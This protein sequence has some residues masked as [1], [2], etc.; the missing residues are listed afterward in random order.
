MR[1]L[2]PGARPLRRTFGR[3]PAWA[4][5]LS[6]LLHG[7]ALAALLGLLAPEAVHEPVRMTGIPLV[8]VG[9]G[10]G[11]TARRLAELPPP[12]SP[13]P[14]EAPETPPVP[15]IPEAAPV[16]PLARPGPAHA[17]PDTPP[18]SEAGS[19]PLPPPDLPSPVAAPAPGQ[20]ASPLALDELPLPP[21]PPSPPQRRPA[22][23]PPAQAAPQP[24]PGRAKLA[25]DASVGGLRL[26]AG[27][28]GLPGESRGPA[29]PAAG[30]AEAI[31]LP[32]AGIGHRN[33][34]FVG[35]RLRLSDNG[36]VVEAKVAV[37]SGFPALDDWARTRIKRCRFTPALRDGRPVWSSYNTSVYF[38]EAH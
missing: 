10:E 29:M 36:R 27:S 35:L 20:G 38:D 14:P 12:A 32:P 17:A 3:A 5:P 22:P 30:C 37:S 23:P 6:L 1:P 7:A 28:G 13:S 26:G 24:D 4:P 25:L 31:G 9:E 15:P 8:W 19:L 11:S 33:A 16:P 2:R 21:P 34:G 18:A